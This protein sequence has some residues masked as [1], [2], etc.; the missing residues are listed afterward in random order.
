VTLYK[1]IELP[2]PA[3]S[4]DTVAIYNSTKVRPGCGYMDLF[5]TGIRLPDSQNLL[6]R[7]D[8]SKW[9]YLDSEAEGRVTTKLWNKPRESGAAVGT[10]EN[11][12]A[13]TS[14][15]TRD[16]NCLQYTVVACAKG[17]KRWV[18]IRECW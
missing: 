2:L 10:E 7:V 17:A 6:C 4:E 3:V 9:T 14:G 16:Q 12:P 13:C 5:V 1:R 15:M 11:D 8:D 18:S